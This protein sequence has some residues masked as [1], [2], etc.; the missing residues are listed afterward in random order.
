M[1]RRVRRSD[2]QPIPGVRELGFKEASGPG[3]FDEL[4]TE[5]AADVLELNNASARVLYNGFVM[6]FSDSIMSGSPTQVADAEEIAVDNNPARADELAIGRV[7]LNDNSA[8]CPKTSAKL[9]LFQLDD[10][11]RVSV[12]D[13]LLE[14]AGIQYEKF[15]QELETRFKQRMH[16]H[17]DKGYAVR[18]LLRF[19]NWL[20]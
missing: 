19:S 14:M 7:S 12:H 18:E 13:T 2:T 3:L 4:A 11:Q 6:G 9:Q 17:E 16:E 5:V 1:M 15:I 20:K 10:A 8:I